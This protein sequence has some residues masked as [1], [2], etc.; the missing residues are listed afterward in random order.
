MIRRSA[1]AF[2]AIVSLALASATQASAQPVP[3]PPT[4]ATGGLGGVTTTIWFDGDPAPTELRC[5]S[6]PARYLV[7]AFTL[8]AGEARTVT[9]SYMT[10]GTS[11]FPLLFGLTAT[12][13][14]PVPQDGCGAKPAALPPAAPSP[15]SSPGGG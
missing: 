8:A 10:D 7:K 12:A 4:P 5:V 1:G 11:W 13:P 15:S 9:G 3:T 14:S 2:S 6:D